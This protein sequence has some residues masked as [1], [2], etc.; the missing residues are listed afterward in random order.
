MR[1]RGKW[2]VMMY[3]LGRSA[4]L[5]RGAKRIARQSPVPVLREQIHGDTGPQGEG[6]TPLPPGFT[7]WA[8]WE[9]KSEEWWGQY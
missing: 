4:S 9:G 2:F 6:R 5:A 8:T 3:M 7:S 1:Y